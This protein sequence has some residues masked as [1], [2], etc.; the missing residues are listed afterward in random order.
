MSQRARDVRLAAPTTTTMTINNVACDHFNGLWNANGQD[1]S[2]FKLAPEAEMGDRKMVVND[3]HHHYH[4]HHRRDY[5]L[6]P[7]GPS[8]AESTSAASG[9]QLKI[10]A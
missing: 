1:E 7:L 2:C 4:H 8:R 5:H 10:A 9:W 3:D 6:P